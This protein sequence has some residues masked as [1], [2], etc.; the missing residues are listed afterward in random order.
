MIHHYSLKKVNGFEGLIKRLSFSGFRSIGFGFKEVKA[1]E[2][3]RYLLA[4]R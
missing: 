4:D 1:D 2:V 3:E